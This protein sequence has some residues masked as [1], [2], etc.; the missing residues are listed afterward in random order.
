MRTHNRRFLEMVSLYR[1]DLHQQS[2]GGS[3][4]AASAEQQQQ[5]P[6]SLLDALPDEVLLQPDN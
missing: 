4:L 1:P 6:S 5:Q 3:V 2:Q